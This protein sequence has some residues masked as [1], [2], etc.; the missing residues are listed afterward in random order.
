MK[1]KRLDAEQGPKTKGM[2]RPIPDLGET[3]CSTET[4]TGQPVCGTSC[5]AVRPIITF[6]WAAENV[7][8]LF[9]NIIDIKFSSGTASSVLRNRGKE[10]K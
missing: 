1:F 8:L 4:L 5:M 3:G 7:F 2:E 9:S 6:A 10:E